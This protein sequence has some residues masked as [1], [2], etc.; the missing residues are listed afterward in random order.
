MW[1]RILW[2]VALCIIGGVLPTV[3]QTPSPDPTPTPPPLVTTV[4]L[5]PDVESFTEEEIEQ[6]ATVV[7]RRLELLGVT[8]Q[9]EVIT[10]DETLMLEIKLPDTFP[11]DMSRDEVVAVLIRR[12][13]LELVD[14]SGLE[15][16]TLAKFAEQSIASTGRPESADDPTLQINPRTG[17]PFETVITNALVETA[18]VQRNDFGEW[19]IW[20][21]LTEEGAALIGEFS[22]EHL[23][24][25]LAIVVD[26]VVV[27]TPII[28][29]PLTDQLV[30]VGGFDEQEAQMLAIQFGSG[31]M[32][33]ALTYDGIVVTD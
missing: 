1:Y 9:V 19:S 3:A 22:R 2:S 29:A 4:F 12:G 24:E 30:V 7:L 16:E 28:N 6:A 17:D 32:P 26:G 33:F 20:V 23:Q 25:P 11:N 14:F 31:V 13:T 21:T 18:E 10:L 5:G 15:P 27:S 8:A